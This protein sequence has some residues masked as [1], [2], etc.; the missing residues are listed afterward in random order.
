MQGLVVASRST[1]VMT[2]T[3]ET[4]LL[5]L[6]G[7]LKT[8]QRSWSLGLNCFT[9]SARLRASSIQFASLLV[10]GL[11]HGKLINVDAK[12]RNGYCLGNLA[13]LDLFRLD[14]RLLADAVS[15]IEVL[16]RHLP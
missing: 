6:G 15:G 7:Y 13:Y 1:S 9:L 2:R 11:N 4:I 5:V 3:L 12:G 8:G 10:W 16:S 14:L